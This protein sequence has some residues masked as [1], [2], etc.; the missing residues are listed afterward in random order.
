MYDVTLAGDRLQLQNV[1]LLGHQDTLFARRRTP[2]APARQL[3]EKVAIEQSAAKVS[4]AAGT[5]AV[6]G[7]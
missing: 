3:I 1:R 4:E 7:K 6:A 5:F 2:E